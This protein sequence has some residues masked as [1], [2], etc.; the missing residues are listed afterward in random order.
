MQG[1]Q[2]VTGLIGG[3]PSKQKRT[4]NEC[5]RERKSGSE[6]EKEPGK[7]TECKR[8]KETPD[9]RKRKAKA[10]RKSKRKMEPY[11]IP[12]YFAVF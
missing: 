6:K 1:F 8:K 10:K 7:E 3:P 9:R 4:G 12:Y 2:E 11:F 5:K